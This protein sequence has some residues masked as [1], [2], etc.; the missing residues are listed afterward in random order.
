MSNFVL[1]FFQYVVFLN[2]LRDAGL[3]SQDEIDYSMDQVENSV[4][5]LERDGEVVNEWLMDNFV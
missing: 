4:R 1:P 2:I 3:I 5:W